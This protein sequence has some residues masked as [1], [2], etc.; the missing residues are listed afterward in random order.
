MVE[1]ATHTTTIGVTGPV[2]PEAFRPHLDHPAG[3]LPTGLGGVPVTAI[4]NEL[5]RR[6]HR[7]VVATLSPD[8]HTDV[9]LRGPRLSLHVGRYRQSGRARDA[10][11]V[12]RRTIERAFEREQVDVVHAHWTYEFALGALS[13]G[14]PTL[15]TI[16]DWAP[17]ILRFHR[18]P[19]R[20]VRLFMHMATLA[21]GR[22]FTTT[23]P[24]IV[25]AAAKWKRAVQLV[26]NALAD[27]WFD[28]RVR[29]LRPHAPVLVSV[30]SGFG[31]RKNTTTLLK[32]FGILR[33]S[34]PRS[35]LLLYGRDYEPHGTAHRWALER[36]LQHGV[37]FE[38]A[39]SHEAAMASIADADVLVHPS[40]EESFGMTL[41]EA[42]A[43]GT[44]AIGG[45]TSG[46]VPWVLAEGAAGKL[47]DVRSPVALAAAMEEMLTDA[48][49]WRAYSR[50]GF[51]HASTNFRLSTVVQQYLDI[52]AAVSRS[53]LSP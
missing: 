1:H 2:T 17:T 25:T 6:G 28:D 43:Q 47:T 37:E 18:D 13:S 16:R 11:R 36:G 41:V 53:S 27:C 26:P 3:P 9:V 29:E 40:L 8:V 7:V 38:G 44:P 50:Q 42:M 35:R 10:F 5:L 45:A 32:A 48:A 21:R 39:V 24:Y 34:S 30:N 14:K 49:R 23:S 31:T 19:Y 15:V 4:V 20:A 51:E 52:Y 33:G 12:E 22:H 46:A